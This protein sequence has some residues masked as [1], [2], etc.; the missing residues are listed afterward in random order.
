MIF[1]K[2]KKRHNCKRVYYVYGSIPFDDLYIVLSSVTPFFFAMTICNIRNNGSCMSFFFSFKMNVYITFFVILILK[3][4]LEL[5]TNVQKNY[6]THSS[7][8]RIS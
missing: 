6:N 5:E 7:F 8:I 3:N 1:N 2:Y 4:N